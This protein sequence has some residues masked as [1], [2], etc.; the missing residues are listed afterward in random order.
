MP[1]PEREVDPA[2]GPVQRLAADLRELRR[3]AGNPGYREL[4]GRTGWSMTALANAAGGSRLPSLPVTLAF[5]QAC[6]GDRADWEHRWQ[7]ASAEW[8]ARHQDHG[9]PPWLGLIGYGEDDADRFFGRREILA[10][11]T[12]MLDEHRLVA[13]FG[14]SG[15]GKSSL[16]RAGLIPAWPGGGCLVT[17]GSEPRKTLR[18]QNL[19]AGTLLVIDQF[20]E[21]FT[22][23]H[24]PAERTAFL[25]ELATPNGAQNGTPGAARIVI[26]VRADFFQRCTEFAPLARLLAGATVPVGP[27]SAAELREVVGEPARRAGLSVERALLTRVIADAEDQPGALPLVSHALLETWRQR[28]GDVLTAAGYETTGGMSG[29]IA[30]TAES[31]HQSLTE[32]EQDTVRQTLTRLVALG[33]GVPDTRRRVRNDELDLAGTGAVL[34]RLLVLG[35]G[36]V[37]IA[38]E[39]LI[40]AWPRLDGWLHHDRETLALHRRLTEASQIWRS[41]DRDPGALYR[42]APLAGWDGRSLHRLNTLEREFLTAGRERRDAERAARRRRSRRTVAGLTAAVVLTSTLA[43]VAGAQALRAGEQ[44]DLA[45]SHQLVASARAQL[46]VDQEVAL[47]LAAEA[48]D[49]RPT[50]EAQ[51]MLRQAVADS[52][53]RATLPAGHG[54][55][56]GVAYDRNGKLICTSGDDGTIRIWRRDGAHGVQPGP[57]VLPT[58]DQAVQSPVFSPDGTRIA[59]AGFDGVVT[60]WNLGGGLPLRLTGHGERI[61]AVAFSPDGARI[62]SAGDDRTVRI[63]TLADPA[64]PV[65][66]KVDG[67]PLSVAFSPD[68]TKLAVSGLGPILIWDA[69]GTGSPRSLPGHESTVKDVTFSPDGTLLASAGTDGTVRIWPLDGLMPPVVLQGNDSYVESVAFSPDGRR[70]ASSHSGSNTIR[71]WGVTGDQDPV[72]MHGHDGAVW[73]VTFSPDG[74]QL[75]SASADG[76]VRFWDARPV[77]DPLVLRD[78]EGA[79]WSVASSADG[80]LIAAGG[81][82]RTV[83]LWREPWHDDPVRLPGNEDEIMAVTVSAD[84]RSVATGGRDQTVRVWDTT[85]AAVRATLRGHTGSVAAVALAPD[86]SRVVSGGK[87]GTVRIWSLSGG[88]PI[89]LNG[90]EDGVRG[91]AFRPDGQRVASVGADGAVRVWPVDGTEPVVVQDQ[92]AGRQVWAADFSPDGRRLAVSG[93]DGAVRVW[94]SDGQ[95]PPVSM[96]GHRDAVWTVAFS[97]DGRLIATSG[98][99]GDGVRIWQAGSGRELVA[100]RGLT[101]S[102][103]QARFL[104]DGRL[105]SAHADG[106]V[107][108][109]RCPVCGPIGE[110]RA[111]AAA[112]TSRSLTAEE[113]EAF[114]VPDR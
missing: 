49:V 29:A 40:R 17:P 35:D 108:I 25:T 67:P 85:T 48:Y 111:M 71:I 38:H 93:Q 50:A 7:R 45:R 86:G 96:R 42:G 82:D 104:P 60:V 68:G 66:L 6:G 90:H 102:V 37:E 79:M 43:V 94:N 99:D 112:A 22:L 8:T 109:W 31:V 64:G 73:T 10:R 56:I 83:R 52:R 110:V 106:T 11:L 41:H 18:Q 9:D 75:A 55:A 105:L 47:L 113:R 61:S 46:D 36:T 100:V 14:A 19:T 30:K 80:R 77:A 20:E 88:P 70:V 24:D 12:E 114:V 63:W 89:V 72:V 33:D 78:G 16:L 4:A 92:P 27:L 84:G 51:T 2:A 15:S 58:G 26:G 34:A 87:D 54:Q 74:T 76:T 95:G 1:R 59:A 5:V 39:A 28:R 98:Q 103:E 21:L 53:V 65:V 3:A 13:V 62:A 81:L 91:V 107:R 44:R 23:C 97:A 57:T 101:T 32:D 69:S